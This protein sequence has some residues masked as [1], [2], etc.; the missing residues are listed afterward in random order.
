MVFFTRAASLVT[1][2]IN[3]TSEYKTLIKWNLRLLKNIRQSNYDDDDDVE[4]VI[5]GG[6]AGLIK[7]YA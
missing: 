2:V 4:N 1:L 3:S 7:F 5:Y 6:G